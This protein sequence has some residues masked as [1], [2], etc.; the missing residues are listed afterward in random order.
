MKSRTR[1]ANPRVSWAAHRIQRIRRATVVVL[2]A[3][4]ALSGCASVQ[5]AD[6]WVSQSEPRSWA[7]HS[8][9]TAGATLASDLITG[10]PWWGYAFAMG[11]QVGWEI[12]EARLTDWDVPWWGTAMDLIAPAVTGLA[13][14]LWLDGRDDDNPGAEPVFEPEDEESNEGSGASAPGEARQG[15]KNESPRPER[16]ANHLFEVSPSPL[17]SVGPQP[18]R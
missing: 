6:A 9:E 1:T 17:W 8:L 12:Q 15:V 2:G 13:V 3:S 16:D 7:V 11:A 14:G 4:G 10:N 5:E 18:E